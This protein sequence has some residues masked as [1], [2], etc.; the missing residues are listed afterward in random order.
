MNYGVGSDNFLLIQ[1]CNLQILNEINNHRHYW[2]KAP[3]W[4]K[5]D[6]VFRMFEPNGVEAFCCANGLMCIADYLNKRYG[7]ESTRIMT[8]IPTATP[9]VVTIGTFSNGETSWANLG[10]PRRMPS[11]I[12][13]LSRTIPYD[14]T[15][16]IL[17]DI[18]I[19]FRKHDLS[20]FSQ[21]QT[22]RISAYLTFTGE[23][24][25]VIFP[26][27]GFSL[28]ELSKLIFV[29]SQE[30]RTK[31]KQVEKRVTFGSWLVD[32]IGNF[33]NKEVEQLFPAGINVNFVQ[34]RNDSGA[35]EY[36]CFERGI[37]KETLACG[38]GALA[39]SCV[40]RQLDLLH[41]DQMFLWPHRSRWHD[42][43][44]QI[45]VKADK[46][47]WVVSGNPVMLLEGVFLLQ[48]SYS[49]K[50]DDAV[51]KTFLTKLSRQAE[52]RLNV[53]AAFIHH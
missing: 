23:P 9:N 52:A 21:A 28:K 41:E 34:V 25:L 14:D 27:T 47:G 3:D 20:P 8:E 26:E 50:K 31:M 40:V 19:T 16:D 1:P 36:R 32:H 53:N 13:D 49:E 18:E 51:F 11:E 43:E 45:R 24:H 6:H 29:S 35:I 46:T 4:K 39:V 48:I 7:V 2:E 33:L 22:L 42:P 38:T 10:Y 30:N 15:V 37:L 44:G 5:A 17:E 12:V